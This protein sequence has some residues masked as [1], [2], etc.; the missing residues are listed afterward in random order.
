MLP[1]HRQP[2]VSVSSIP[3]RLSAI[4]SIS[5]HYPTTVTLSLLSAMSPVRLQ[6]LTSASPMSHQSVLGVS[7]IHYPCALQHRESVV[8]AS[9]VCH[10]LLVK[11]STRSRNLVKPCQNTVRVLSNL[12]KT[13]PQHC[14]STVRVL[15]EH[16]Q[17]VMHTESCIARSSS[18][19]P[20]KSFSVRRQ[21]VSE[22]LPF[23]SPVLSPS[24]P[25]SSTSSRS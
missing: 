5:V 22:A 18:A 1:R 9:P 6:C 12:A 4:H 2:V 21:I 19:C 10:R 11:A 16:S 20:L 7:P 24:R 14:H 17:E 25:R 13:L 8:I 15:S 3:R 23:H